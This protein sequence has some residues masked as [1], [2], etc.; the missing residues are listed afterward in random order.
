MHRGERW[1]KESKTENLREREKE[2]GREKWMKGRNFRETEE[3]G[4]VGR[5][6]WMK[7]TK[8]EEDRVRKEI[9]RR[10]WREEN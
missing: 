7:G 4:W 2:V 5:E 10:Q 9:V 1:K 8:R 6:K 3:E